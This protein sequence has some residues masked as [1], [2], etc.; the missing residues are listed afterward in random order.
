MLLSSTQYYIFHTFISPRYF[1]KQNMK[2]N[3]QIIFLF[4]NIILVCDKERHLQSVFSMTP[5]S[6]TIWSYRGGPL[7]C[8]YILG[9]RME[10]SFAMSVH[11]ILWEGAVCYSCVAVFLFITKCTHYRYHYRCTHHVVF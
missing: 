4:H 2:N 10:I 3:K 11:Q 8:L 6:L 1:S 7:V 5:G 9:F